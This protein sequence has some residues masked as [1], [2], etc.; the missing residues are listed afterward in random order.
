M[1][2]TKRIKFNKVWEEKLEFV[3]NQ[4]QRNRQKIERTMEYRL[5]SMRTHFIGEPSSS[6]SALKI[7]PLENYSSR[8]YSQHDT[9]FTRLVCKLRQR[10]S[11]STSDSE[12][13]GGH[14]PV[15]M[16]SLVGRVKRQIGIQQKNQR[17]KSI[18]EFKNLFQHLLFLSDSPQLM[19]CYLVPLKRWQRQRSRR[20]I[21]VE[22]KQR[23]SFDSPNIHFSWRYNIISYLQFVR[24]FRWLSRILAERWW[25]WVFISLVC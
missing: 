3:K 17:H 19:I 20:N 2:T 10:A 18:S 4:T 1:T 23:S 11:T 7:E 16:S 8:C 21:H 14:G 12:E 13:W 25:P 9:Q 6:N 15:I 24:L 22:E 5:Q